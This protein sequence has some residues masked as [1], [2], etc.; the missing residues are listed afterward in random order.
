MELDSGLL[1][2]IQLL[3]DDSLRSAIAGV[4]AGMGLDPAMTA[5]Y[6]S[7]MGKVKKT[8]SELTQEDFSRLQ[9]AIGE[10]NTRNLVEHIRREVKG[11]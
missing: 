11:D 10:E 1:E 2:K 3:D 9:D 5:M 6:L 4:A 8:V 7:D